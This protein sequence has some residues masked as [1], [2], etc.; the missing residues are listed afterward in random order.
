[1][2][3]D[4]NEYFYDG[5]DILSDSFVNDDSVNDSDFMIGSFMC[6]LVIS[7]DV[8]FLLFKIFCRNFF[9]L[10]NFVVRVGGRLDLLI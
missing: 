10:L 9:F 7:D 8:F 5:D 6:Y 4:G 1:M 3:E 2:D